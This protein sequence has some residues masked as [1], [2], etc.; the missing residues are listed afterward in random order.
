MTTTDARTDATRTLF[1]LPEPRERDLDEMTSYR[2][3]YGPG[4]PINLLTHFGNL[5]S[6]L[7]GADMWMTASPGSRPLLQPDLVIAFDIDVEQY[8]DQNGYVISDQGKPPDFVLEVA[9]PSTA[10]RDTG[11]KRVEYARMGIAEYWRFDHTG[12]D[13]GARLAGDRLVGASYVPIPIAEVAPDVLEGRSDALNLILRWDHGQM[14][15]I[16][17][18]TQ[19]PIPGLESERAARI[20]AEQ[21]ARR[22]QMQA[23]RA[24]ARARELE[25]ELQRLQQRPD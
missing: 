23:D 14:L 16:D 24:E 2:Y 4:A 13:H 5:E 1:R 9:S 18:A 10:E 3:V 25:A 8:Y 19:L 6:T 20:E 12:D 21:Q 22:A 15:W 11:Y 7:V 17:P